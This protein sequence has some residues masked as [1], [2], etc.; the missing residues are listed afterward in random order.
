MCLDRTH[1]KL[2]GVRFD[3]PFAHVV[4]VRG[5]EVARH[6]DNGIAE[7][8][9]TTLTVS[10]TTIIEHLQE[11]GD[12]LPCSFLDFINENDGVGFPTNVLGKLT[13]LIV[14]DITRGSTNETGDRVLLR[15]FRAIDTDHSVWGVEENGSELR[16]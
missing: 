9:D 2:S 12:E 8:D 7:V 4:E 1:N 10:Q 5:T 15:V 13:A 11:E 3:R 14:P 6:D 16:R